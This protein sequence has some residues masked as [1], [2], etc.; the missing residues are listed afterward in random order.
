LSGLLIFKRIKLVA[1]TNKSSA[2]AEMGDR[3]RAKRAEKW[4]HCSGHCCAPFRGELSPH[5]TMPPG[6]RHTSV[7]SG[8]LIRL[9][10]CPQYTKV[11]DRQTDR[12][13]IP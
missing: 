12:T 1:S 5:L 9:T 3:V 2:V 13:M 6:L 8:I 4:G 11:T 10:V 7:P